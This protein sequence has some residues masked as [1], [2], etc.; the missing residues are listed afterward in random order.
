MPQNPYWAKASSLLRIHNQTYIYAPQSVEIVWKSDQQDAGTSTLQ[1]TTLTRDR[2][3]CPW[4]ERTNNP[5]KLV[6][7][8]PRHR[9]QISHVLIFK[10]TL[11]YIL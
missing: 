1:H 11:T 7:V 8:E 10:K 6:A 5:S 4:R 9:G 2:Q 3:T